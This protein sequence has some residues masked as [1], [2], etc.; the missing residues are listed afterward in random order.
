MSAG[1]KYVDQNAFAALQVEDGASNQGPSSSGEGLRKRKKSKSNLKAEKPVEKQVNGHQ[2]HQNGHAEGKAQST[3]TKSTQSSPASK[4]TKAADATSSSPSRAKARPQSPPAKGENKDQQGKSG[5][6]SRFEQFKGKLMNDLE[7]LQVRLK[8]EV[9]TASAMQLSE[10][11]STDC[12]LCE[13][14]RRETTPSLVRPSITLIG[15]TQ[16]DIGKLVLR[17]S[18]YSLQ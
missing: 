15:N 16:T 17:S 9:S 5:K 3:P 13:R 4:G 14:R 10:T 6:P 8:K 7:D 11:S 2:G 12:R 18:R 1:R